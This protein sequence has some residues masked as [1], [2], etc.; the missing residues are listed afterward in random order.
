[1]NSTERVVFSI[2]EVYQLFWFSILLRSSEKKAAI[3]YNYNEEE[4]EGG[5]GNEEKEEEEEEEEEEEDDDDILSDDEIDLGMVIVGRSLFVIL[6]IPFEK[7][8]RS[9]TDPYICIGI[10]CWCTETWLVV[11]A[12]LYILLTG[13]S[14]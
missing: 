11:A 4:G 6:A 10:I 9:L 2:S 3:G 14:C 13:C 8:G 5:D 12:C 7:V 1:M